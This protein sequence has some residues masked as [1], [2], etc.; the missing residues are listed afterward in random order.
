MTAAAACKLGLECKIVLGGPDFTTPKGNLLLDVIFGA[1]IRYLVDD[2]SNDR[3]T[4]EMEKWSD[5]L[6]KRGR[7]SF[8]IPIGGSSGLA[9]LGYVKA[10]RELA[11]QFGN[12]E[13]QVILPVGSCGTIA[14]VILGSKMFMPNARVIGISVSR[15]ADAIKQRTKELINESASL[16]NYEINADEI[17]V[18]CYDSYHVEYG[19]LTES[20]EKAIIDSA[21][22]EGI[23]LDPIYTAKSMAGLI[24]LTN[25]NIVDKTI[26][27][28]FAHTGGT[29]I[30]F[31]FESELGKNINCKKIYKQL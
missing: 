21:W 17:E 24:D 26:P 25:K 9:A 8:I 18:E 14:G 20:G 11:E 1:E 23:L 29:P 4:L 22:L 16:I 15:T 13:V 2:D 7:K 19:T 30:I 28:I 10:M 12:E 5:E 27:V 31:S 6:K 3:L